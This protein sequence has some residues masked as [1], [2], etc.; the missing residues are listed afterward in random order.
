MYVYLTHPP[1][2]LSI[3]FPGIGSGT[4]TTLAPRWHRLADGE[5]IEDGDEYRDPETGRWHRAGCIGKIV[6]IPGRTQYQ[7]RRREVVS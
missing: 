3:A 2:K 7:Y 4:T 5:I 1:M 6:G